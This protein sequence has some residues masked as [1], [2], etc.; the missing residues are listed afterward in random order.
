MII[1][2]TNTKIKNVIIFTKYLSLNYLI[3]KM[4]LQIASRVDQTSNPRQFSISHTHFIVITFRRQ[5]F[6]RF[7]QSSRILTDRTIRKMSHVANPI[8][9]KLIDDFI[10]GLDNT[11]IDTVLPIT[12]SRLIT[13]SKRP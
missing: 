11:I 5:F 8:R 9:R 13:F 1:F 10:C 12:P 3:I 6:C 4:Q 7:L 2:L